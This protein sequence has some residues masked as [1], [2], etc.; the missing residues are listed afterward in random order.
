MKIRDT[1]SA[2]DKTIKELTN[3]LTEAQYK[4]QQTELMLQ[5]QKEELLS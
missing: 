4:V 3:S 1:I 5:K 2:K